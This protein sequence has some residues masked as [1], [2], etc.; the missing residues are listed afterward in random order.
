MND[1]LVAQYGSQHFA[2][3]D[4]FDFADYGGATTGVKLA[5]QNIDGYGIG[6]YYSW[7]YEGGLGGS[8]WGDSYD[9][10][11]GVLG[12]IYSDLIYGS[13]TGTAANLGSG[14][15]IFDTRYYDSGQDVV[16]GGSGHDDIW[17][18]A[19]DDV[20]DG[21]SGSDY[22]NGELGNDCLKGGK[23]S[24]SIYGGYGDDTLS[25]GTG[26]DYLSGGYGTDFV[27]YSDA[28]SGISAAFSSNCYYGYS[29]DWWGYYSGG[30]R[31]EAYGDNYHS[32]EGII[33]SAYDDLVIGALHGTIAELGDG[34]DEFFGASSWDAHDVVDG[35]T[36]NDL[37]DT[38]DGDDQLSG[39]AGNDVLI[40][41]SGAD[42]FYFADGDG[43]DNIEDFHATYW[44][45]D[46]IE[47][48]VD[49]INNFGDVIAHASET[50]SGWYTS[51]VL[52]FGNDDTLTLEG[53]WI[54][55][56]TADDFIF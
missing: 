38:G 5:L 46:K 42:T 8:A 33:G 29:Y 2:G 7:Y 28:S 50:D 54:S 15:D 13:A 43:N 4:G 36:G 26:A 1:L 14:N 39:G 32:I 20:V 34:N 10:I 3:G 41:G 25:G 51:T 37:I 48:D 22:I 12:S 16:L 11:E 55:Q 9:S 18:G 27:D 56:L 31:G 30:F 19:G 52:D 44:E 17:T 40:G 53:I 45:K 47:L 49:G 35:G 23:G 6:G 21:G 24:D